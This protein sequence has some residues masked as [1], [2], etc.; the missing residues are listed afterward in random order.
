VKISTKLSEKPKGGTGQ[1]SIAQSGGEVCT[2][3]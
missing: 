3:D 2:S 1:L